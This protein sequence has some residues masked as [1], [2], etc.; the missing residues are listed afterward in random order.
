MHTCKT[1]MSIFNEAGN[2][3]YFQVG[4]FKFYYNLIIRLGSLYSLKEN[5]NLQVPQTAREMIW[6][7]VQLLQQTTIHPA[8]FLKMDCVEEK[9]IS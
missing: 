2:S 9:L 8:N 7:R 4:S 1:S 5:K 6:V 3:H